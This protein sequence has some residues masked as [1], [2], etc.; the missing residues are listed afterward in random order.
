MKGV[1]FTEFL[2]MV[3]AKFGLELV[4]QLIESSQLPSGGAYTSVGT[5][6]YQELIELVGHLSNKSS[7]PVP[8]LVKAFG[9]YLFQRFITLYPFVL[10]GVQTASQFLASVEGLI[11]VEV[12][13]LYPDAELPELD[14]QAGEKGWDLVYRSA[15]P[16][17]DL[18]EGLVSECLEHFGDRGTLS[19]QD[20]ETG[21]GY[22][23]RFSF[24]ANSGE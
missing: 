8:E 12:K 10:K 17:A 22:S 3:E 5:Y 18:C 1:V 24:Q 14:F 15:R 9:H 7:V 6:S 11:H 19:R 16:F 4:D 13:K 21:V 23:A 2:E 20:I